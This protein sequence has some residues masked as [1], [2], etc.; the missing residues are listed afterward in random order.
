MWVVT[1]RQ[2]WK[3][4]SESCR[5]ENMNTTLF[6]FFV[7]F[8]FAS[9][10]HDLKSKTWEVF[11][12]FYAHK[13]L[14]FPSQPC[15]WSLLLCHHNSSTC[16]VWP[17]MML[18]YKAFMWPVVTKYTNF[19][20]INHFVVK[21]VSLDVVRSSGLSLWQ[22][23]AHLCSNQAVISILICHTWQVDGPRTVAFSL[24]RNQTGLNQFYEQN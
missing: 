9:I 11:F 19:T 22:A 1:G 15:Q 5:E 7:F 24:T 6:F 4:E 20:K 13:R 12:F 23:K 18:N 8:Y 2:R 21:F 17:V 3:R 14:L 10:S 16:Q